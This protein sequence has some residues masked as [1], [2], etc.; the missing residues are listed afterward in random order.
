MRDKMMNPGSNE[1]RE[2]ESERRRVEKMRWEEERKE[3]WVREHL[4]PLTVK[5]SGCLSSAPLGADSTR[6]L[7]SH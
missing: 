2:G 6:A 5:V 7:I 1:D 3:K 4:C